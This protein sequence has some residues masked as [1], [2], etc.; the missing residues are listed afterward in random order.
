MPTITLHGRSVE[1]RLLRTRRNRFVRLTIT[2]GKGLRV[3]A[4]PRFPEREIPRIIH[5][6]AAWVLEKL[7]E[8][9]KLER[10]IPRQRFTDGAPIMFLG[11][12]HHLCIAQASNGAVHV[13]VREN[14]IH[15]TL[16]AGV[17]AARRE[18]MLR[19]VLLAWLK[20]QAQRIVLPRVEHYARQMRVSPSRISIRRQNTR[21]GSCSAKGNVN[22]NQ[23][24]VMAPLA[25]LDYVIV[26]ELAHL[27]ELNHS[28]RFWAI[29]DRYC[30]ERAKHQA[31]LKEHIHYL[32][33]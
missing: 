31:W 8:F 19:D 26:H 29:V 4:P 18:N 24:L 7:D 11:R 17:P 3:S 10:A 13:R 28:S 25:V 1:Y 21:W 12:R 15:I 20:L 23:M 16:P 33:L 27:S 22:L 9:A 14:T 2:V 6:R 5:E 30:P 32:D